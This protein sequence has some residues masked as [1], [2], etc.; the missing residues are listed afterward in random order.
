MKEFNGICV[1]PGIAIGPVRKFTR[2][3]NN[4]SRLIESVDKEKVLLS[5]AI[6]TAQ[7][8]LVLLIERAHKGEKDIFVFQSCLLEDDGLL[9]EATRY[10]EAC[11]GAAAAMERVGQLYAERMQSME[12]EYMQLRAVDVLDVCQRVVDILDGHTRQKLTLSH[13][14]ILAAESLMPSD[15]FGAPDGMILGIA[16]SHGSTQSHA[17]IIARALGLPSVI[18]LGDAFLEDCDGKIAALDAGKGTLLL[19]PDADT[20]QEYMKRIYENQRHDSSFAALRAQP[21]I[22]K[23]GASFTLMANCFFPEDIAF[24]MESGADGVGLLRTE[25]LALHGQIAS[26]SQQYDFYKACLKA[27]QGKPLTI[28][29]LDIGANQNTGDLSSK[30]QPSH[31]LGLRGIRFSRAQPRLFENQICA[32]LRAGARG[33]IQVLLPMISCLEDWLFAMKAVARCKEL[34]RR[35]KVT[36]NENMK[37]GMIME[38]PSACL[39]AEEFIEMG[40]EFFCIGTN[41]LVQYTHAADRNL[42]ALEPYYQT[43][44]LAI[45][46]LIGIV[47]HA[48]KEADIPVSVSGLSVSSAEHAISYLQQG[49]RSFSMAPHNILEVKQQLLNAYSGDLARVYENL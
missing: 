18:Q 42:S 16:A 29:T 11:A 19:T 8:E 36:F 31:A 28:R 41:D 17:A 13:P 44:S 9:N 32:L 33:D 23:D 35:R 3:K 38:V 25:S 7:E 49:V 43:N 48:A 37:F 47:M 22:T 24:S 10:I 46:K 30:R 39:M 5:E 27:A 12:S 2:S 1:A 40:C 21:C 4:F 34:L 15:L 14:V 45:Q 6:E 20:R 26:E